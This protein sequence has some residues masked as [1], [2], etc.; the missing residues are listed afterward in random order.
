M[1]N[2]V[3]SVV[4]SRSQYARVQSVLQELKSDS[5]IDF[6]LIVSG[7][8]LVHRFGELDE[9]IEEA[10]L[11]VDREI[12]TLLEAGEPIAQAKTTG[13][14]LVEYATAFEEIAPDVLLTSGDR[15]E[16]MAV[17]LAASYL[18]IPVIHLEGGEITG[19]IDDKVRHA[20]TKMADY[21]FVSTARAKTLV[22]NLGESSNRVTRTGCPSID[23]AKEITENG[24]E[25]YDPQEEY[26]G[27][28]DFVD[29]SS[30]YIVIQYHPI[31]TDYASNYE[32]TRELIEAYEQVDVQAFW[33]WPNMDAGTDQVSKA[34]REYREHVDPKGVRFFI[35]L[36]P[37]DYLT[38]VFNSKGMVGN[39][40]VGIREC[41]YFGVPTVNIGDRQQNRERG[42]NVTDVECDADGIAAAIENQLNNGRYERSELYGSG[43]AAQQITNEIAALEPTLKRPMTPEHLD[44]AGTHQT[45]AE[46]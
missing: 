44:L 24:H 17:T 39:S 12:H 28:G 11:E 43:N 46:R 34:M 7:G 9:A 35:S 45:H 8:A 30:D 5:R 25:R 42:P 31:P 13:L 20:T 23:L 10:G 18:N 15:Y 2:S 26:G 16:T 1:V 36:D 6:F 33:F 22:E 21:H 14:G 41:S 3:A 29:T 40:S 37:I 27:V 32:K 19:S 4:T 38:L